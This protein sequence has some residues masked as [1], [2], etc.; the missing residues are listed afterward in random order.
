MIVSDELG[1]SFDS[2]DLTPWILIGLGAWI[3]VE[4]FRSGKRETKFSRK[5]LTRKRI[6][7]AKGRKISRSKTLS[8]KD[9]DRIFGSIFSEGT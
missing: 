3:V 2:L 6:L 1:D 8:K 9:E 7:E 5:R 4:V